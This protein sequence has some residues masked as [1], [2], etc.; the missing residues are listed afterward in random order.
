MNVSFT[1]TF[2]EV[3]EGVGAVLFTLKKT[4]G[5]VGQVSVRLFTVEDSASGVS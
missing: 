4:L 1:Q 2:F 3:K 5:A